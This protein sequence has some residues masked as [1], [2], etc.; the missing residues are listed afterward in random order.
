VWCLSGDDG[1]AALA[2]ELIGNTKLVALSLENADIEAEGAEVLINA[3]EGNTAMI[4]ID[5]DGNTIGDDGCLV[6]DVTTLP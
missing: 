4:S 2:E 3:L 1:A 6:G 5:L